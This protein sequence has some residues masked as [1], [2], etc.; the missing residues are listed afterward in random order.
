MRRRTFIQGAGAAVAGI[1]G[2]AG[3]PCAGRVA[4]A[5]TGDPRHRALAA[6]RRERRARPPAR[7]AAAGQARRD[8]RGREPG[9]RRRAGRHQ[10]GDPGRARRLHAARERV[11]HRRDAAGAEGREFRPGDRP[12]GRGAH[13]ARAAGPADDGRAPAA[14]AGGGGGSRQ[15]Q[16]ARLGDRDLVARLGR[17][18]R[19]HRVQPAHRCRPADWCRIAARRRR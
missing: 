15:G 4:A 16:S 18:S 2:R 11:Q 12:R 19:H 10:R 3:G 14:D 8:R 9:R 5:R 13:R 1:A 17:A 6:R 7:A